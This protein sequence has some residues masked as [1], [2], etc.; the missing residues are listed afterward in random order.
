MNASYTLGEQAHIVGEKEDAAR[1]KS[2]LSL[3]ERNSYHNVILLCPTCHTNIDENEE[4]WPI[5]LLHNRKSQH[6][7]WVTETL[8][9]TVDHVRLANETATSFLIDSAV[10]KCRLEAWK[11]WSSYALSSDPRWREEHVDSIY[12]FRQQLVG[13]IWPKDTDELK[14]ATQTLGILL[15]RATCEFLEHADLVNEVWLPVKFYKL[16]NPNPNYDRDLA[17]YEAWL[18]SCYNFV[19]EATKAA[20]WFADIVRKDI[21]PMFFV[22]HGKFIFEEGLF[23]DLSYRTRLLEFTDEEKE[24]FPDAALTL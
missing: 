22:E 14:R 5:E 18:K 13:A 12:D 24:T 7:L 8:S 3:E 4:D 17:K 20:N 6:E 19:Y 1:G 9:E 21:N 16:R 15:H 11:S 23:I 10:T 2:T